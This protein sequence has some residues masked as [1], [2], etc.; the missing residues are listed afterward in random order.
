LKEIIGTKKAP[1][2]LGP[3]SQ[4][5]KIKTSEMLFCSGQLPIDPISGQLVTG[6]VVEQT[7]RVMENLKAVI[8]ASGFTM[9][10][11]VKT[12]IYLTDLGVFD[13]INRVYGSYF[14]GN[15]PARSTVQIAALPRGVAVEIDAVACR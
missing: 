3:Y 7:Q 12:T 4:A 8:E 1:A 14:S 9:D 15:F 6:S 5:V 2:A 10:D 11:V 13:E